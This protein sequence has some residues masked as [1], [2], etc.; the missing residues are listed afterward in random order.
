[1][2]TL[3]D[4]KTDRD[5][6]ITAIC[7]GFFLLVFPAYFS[8]AASG[9]DGAAGM[10]GVRDYEVSGELTYVEL[11]SGGEYIADGTTYN[12]ENLHTD[13]IDGAD[14]MNI[15]GV[16]LT[17]SYGEDD[18]SSNGGALSP[19]SIPGN[20]N[21]QADTISGDTEHLGFTGSASG[22][23]GGQGGSH[24]AEAIWY[25]DSMI[26]VISGLSEAEIV[27]QIDAMGAGLGSYN[28]SVSVTAETGGGGG[29]QHT[30]DGEDVSYT[31]ELIVF[32]YTIAPFIELSDV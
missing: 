18:E 12:I 1:M 22:Q 10:G 31:V 29:C 5:T 8:F 20:D 9:V 14:D 13:A 21:N 16:R 23:N 24:F 7:I 27:E 3:D 32:D 4:L 15:V 2:W 30:D 28:A 6:Q 17:M 11:A 25:N 26:G 19:C